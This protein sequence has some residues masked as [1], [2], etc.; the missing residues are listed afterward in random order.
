MYSSHLL[1]LDSIKSL[2]DHL[3]IDG[4]NDHCDYVESS[5]IK[6]IH[7]NDRDLS[8]LQLNIRGLLNKQCQ[9]KQFLSCDNVSLPIDVVLLCETW[10][11]PTTSELFNLPN[12]KSFH[13]NQKRSYWWWY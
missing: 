10:L 9:I 5:R 13:K 4:L 8:V 1:N 11:K 7:S 3:S 2:N 6:D 12:Y